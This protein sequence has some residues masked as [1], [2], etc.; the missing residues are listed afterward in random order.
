MEIPDT[1][2]PFKKQG[3]VIWYDSTGVYL[4]NDDGET[5]H[6]ENDGTLNDTS[7]IGENE[8]TSK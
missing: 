2:F 8:C 1:G 4:I 7:I 5:E 3:K 6:R